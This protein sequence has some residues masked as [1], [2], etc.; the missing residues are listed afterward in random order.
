[1]L[2]LEALQEALASGPGAG[3]AGW[4]AAAGR[5]SIGQAPNLTPDSHRN[6]IGM[7]MAR[8][9]AAVP[10]G[11]APRPRTPSRRPFGARVRAAADRRQERSMERVRAAVILAASRDPG[12]REAIGGLGPAAG[13]L[14]DQ[15]KKLLRQAEEGILSPVDPTLDPA[16]TLRKELDAALESGRSYL[17]EVVGMEPPDVEEILIGGFGAICRTVGMDLDDPNHVPFTTKPPVDAPAPGT[18]GADPAQARGNAPDGPED[19]S[20][21]AALPTPFGPRRPGRR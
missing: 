2:G 13:P 1:M 3:A 9:S 4:M 16:Q 17:G 11:S 10:E 6:S 19:A 21:D 14:L 15:A 18:P 20:S 8:R 12:L 5:A 7:N